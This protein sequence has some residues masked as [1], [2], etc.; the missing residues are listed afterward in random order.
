MNS[1][2]DGHGVIVSCAI[3]MVC[4]ISSIAFSQTVA[5]HQVTV[6]VQPVSLIQ[7]SVG[8]I[9]LNITGANAVA[10]QDQMSIS[11]QSCNL[12]WGTNSSLQ[13]ITAST[14]LVSPVYTV[15]LVAIAPSS[16]TAMPEFPISSTPQDLLQNIGRSAGTTTLRYTAIALASQGI[17]TDSH[18]ITFTFQAQ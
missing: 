6:T 8:T 14:S 2:F 5:N 11:D 12:L 10:G 17:G 7:V 9:T 16:G 18:V 3:I 15:R 1:S 13:K 4:L